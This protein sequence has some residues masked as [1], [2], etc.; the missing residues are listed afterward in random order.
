MSMGYHY[1]G[2]S[3]LFGILESKKLW[4]TRYDFL[5]DSMECRMFDEAVRY[6]RDGFME[7][8]GLD[9]NSEEIKRYDALIE[10]MV[11]NVF[12]F[13]LSHG[14]DQLS[15]WTLYGDGGHGFALEFDLLKIGI[16]GLFPSIHQFEKVPGLYGL[17]VVYDMDDF[18]RSYCS[19]HPKYSKDS[20]DVDVFIEMRKFAPGFKHNCFLAEKEYRIV[21]LPSE[22]DVSM[23]MK[24]RVSGKRITLYY[25]IECFDI[26][27]IILGPKNPMTIEQVESVAESLWGTRIKAEKSA[28][29]YQ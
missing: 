14:Y 10:S 12:V 1:C 6:F 11:D 17:P 18:Y 24:S 16:T 5:N 3:G 13:S 15:Q 21:Y 19:S 26:N 29:P 22:G 9:G 4:L 25:E 2:V 7:N 20:L 28:L 27:K 8:C 23:Q